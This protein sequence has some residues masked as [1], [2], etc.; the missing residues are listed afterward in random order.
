MNGW[1]HLRGL[2]DSHAI[3][4]CYDFQWWSFKM[5]SDLSLAMNPT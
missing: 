2:K 3:D 4:M 1:K 5:S